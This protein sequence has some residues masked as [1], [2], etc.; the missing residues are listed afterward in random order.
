MDAVI[1]CPYGSIMKTRRTTTA[2]DRSAEV[3]GVAAWVAAGTF[4]A[5]AA[6][7]A[8]RGGTPPPRDPDALAQAGAMFGVAM[9]GA[10]VPVVGSLPAPRWAKRAGYA[11]I[12]IDIA[13]N[14]LTLGGVTEPTTTAVR[15]V[16]HV[17][18]AAWILLASR[19]QSRAI[20]VIG[21]AL[22][23]WLF[24]YTIL[25]PVV[26]DAAFTPAVPLMLAWLSLVARGFR[27]QRMTPAAA[28]ALLQA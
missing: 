10:L 3:A 15:L 17:G 28:T 27:T 12:V 11:W 25:A 22:A 13:A 1:P 4:G 7:I 8:M 20:R 18:A 23:G 2:G 19:C 9:H 6:T 21:T 14:S 5:L 16:G 26:P 24:G